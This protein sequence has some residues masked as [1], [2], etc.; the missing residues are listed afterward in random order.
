[1]FSASKSLRNHIS[2][3]AS[4]TQDFWAKLV[5]KKH[6]GFELKLAEGDEGPLPWRDV[7]IGT[8]RK[9]TAGTKH[10]QTHLAKISGNPDLSEAERLDQTRSIVNHLRSAIITLY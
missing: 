4:E 5:L 2:W 1:M 10:L 7:F 9:L 3:K 6:P 8:E